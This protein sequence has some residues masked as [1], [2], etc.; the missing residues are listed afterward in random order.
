MNLWDYIPKGS[1]GEYVLSFFYTERGASGSSCYMQFTLPSVSSAT[2]EQNTGH[3]RVEKE[4]IGA[5]PDLEQEFTF[6]IH[7]KDADG[8]HLPDD[9]AY[10]RYRSDGTVV[11][12]DIILFDGGSFKLKHG[13]YIIV[14]YLP[15]GTVYTVEERQGSGVYSVT[16]GDEA[17]ATAT[18]TI[19]TKMATEIVRYT[20]TFY[21]ELPETGGGGAMAYR[22]M[23]SGMLLLLPI[24]YV[25]KRRYR[26]R[27]VNG[28]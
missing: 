28:G 17:T 9:Y 7:F 13:E 12:T 24:L 4:S 25:A 2:P 27:R 10:T 1:S 5:V 22:L 26:G 14:K 15:I 6:D 23:G 19:A 3:L 11:E 18:G 16:V 20:N 8:N 21:Y